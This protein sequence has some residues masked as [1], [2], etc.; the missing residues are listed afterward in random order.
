ME[1]PVKDKQLRQYELLEYFWAIARAADPQVAGD[2]LIHS[3]AEQC[4]PQY[5][6]DMDTYICG[7][8]VGLFEVCLEGLQSVPHDR[9][10]PVQVKSALS[11]IG[12]YL[13]DIKD[14]KLAEL[15]E[16]INGAQV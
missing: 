6:E 11:H 14:P 2:M 13:T 16:M 4:P 15:K 3:I 8:L 7:K 9:A 5:L 12:Q 10:T 1:K